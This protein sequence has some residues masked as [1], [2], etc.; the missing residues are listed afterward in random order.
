[1]KS[2]ELSRTSTDCV[3][4]RMC[5]WA[6]VADGHDQYFKHVS[7]KNGSTKLTKHEMLAYQYT[8]LKRHHGL[9]LFALRLN[10]RCMVLIFLNPF[11][12]QSVSSTSTGMSL[13]EATLERITK[14]NTKFVMVLLRPIYYEVKKWSL[15]AK[16][17]GG[18]PLFASW[19]KKDKVVRQSSAAA[20]SSWSRRER[21][22]FTSPSSC[23]CLSWR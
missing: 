15:L 12:S 21:G 23:S 11:A 13:Q 9:F 22:N 20:Q 17:L 5:P 6:S 10:G 7:E 4:V 2:Y 16:T 18:R 8:S 14:N 3:S 1:M 19:T